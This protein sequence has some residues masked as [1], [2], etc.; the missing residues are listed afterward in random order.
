M[1]TTRE[2]SEKKPMDRDGEEQVRIRAYEF[3]L[4]RAEHPGDAMQDWLDA[5]REYFGETAGDK[6]APSSGE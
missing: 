5:E 4:N 1:K 6:A 2:E 3:S